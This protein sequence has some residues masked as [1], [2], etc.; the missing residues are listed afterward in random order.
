MAVR[1]V[2]ATYSPSHPD[3]KNLVHAHLD[4][5]KHLSDYM[6]FLYKNDLYGTPCDPIQYEWPHAADFPTPFLSTLER[7]RYED[8]NVNPYH[9]PDYNYHPEMGD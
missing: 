5:E 2:A 4:A 3:H 8:Y 6:L 9:I 1:L 7:M